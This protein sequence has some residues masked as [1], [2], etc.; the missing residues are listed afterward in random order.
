[1]AGTHK[2]VLIFVLYKDNDNC[3]EFLLSNLSWMSDE[4]MGGGEEYNNC[5]IS[6]KRKR[7]FDRK[8]Q[9]VRMISL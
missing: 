9:L 5:I 7:L 4:L 2:N 6:Y 1:M 3:L 8:T